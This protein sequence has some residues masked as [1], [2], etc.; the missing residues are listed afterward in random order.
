VKI[1]NLHIWDN[2]HQFLTLTPFAMLPGLDSIDFEVKVSLYDAAGDLIREEIKIARFYT[3]EQLDYIP[4]SNVLASY[5]LNGQFNFYKEESNQRYVLLKQGQPNLFYNIP[6]GFYQ[7][8]ELRASNNQG[9]VVWE[10]PVSYN[11]LERKVSFVTPHQVLQNEEMYQ[12]RI[13]NKPIPAGSGGMVET[14]VVETAGGGLDLGGGGGAPTGPTGSNDETNSSTSNDNASTFE[15]LDLNGDG[16]PNGENNDPSAPM[17]HELYAIY[18]RVST[19][20]T[21]NEKVLGFNSMDTTV[22]AENHALDVEALGLEKFDEFE[23][24]GSEKTDPLLSFNGNLSTIIWFFDTIAPVTYHFLNN[25]INGNT[26]SYLNR[27]PEVFGDVPTKAVSFYQSPPDEFS[28]EVQIKVNKLNYQLN[29]INYNL[30]SPRQTLK[31]NVFQNIRRD[32][33]DV[34]YQALNHMEEFIEGIEQEKQIEWELQDTEYEKILGNDYS[35]PTVP[36]FNYADHDPPARY[37]SVQAK[38]TL[39]GTNIVTSIATF[40]LNYNYEDPFEN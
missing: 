35:E 16:N 7:V 34:K 11:S 8:I 25:T 15:S 2:A 1:W 36:A 37:Y 38:Y 22:Y 31:Y 12:L 26:L 24:N 13:V 32:F 6:D 5:P 30:L 29:F 19:Y 39:P 18:F 17:P 33:N 3:S 14:E 40:V 28:P 27:D 20:D 9:P 23:I 10:S 4:E 21:F